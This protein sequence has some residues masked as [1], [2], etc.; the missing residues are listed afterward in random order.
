MEN[1]AEKFVQSLS[2]NIP[3][4]IQVFCYNPNIENSDCVFYLH[5]DC[6]NSCYMALRLKQGIS[7]N[8]K[9]GLERFVARYGKDW[10]EIAFAHG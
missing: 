9:T 1:K 2:L 6:P 10:R 7:H 4:E 8:V 3:V 5:Q